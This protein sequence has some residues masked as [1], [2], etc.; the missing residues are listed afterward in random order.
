MR[1]TK[2]CSHEIKY[3][4]GSLTGDK[5]LKVEGFIIKT[6]LNRE[7]KLWGDPIQ[8]ATYVDRSIY[9]NMIHR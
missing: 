2:I 8:G 6:T 4:K 3:L 5:F 7:L 1:L 9:V